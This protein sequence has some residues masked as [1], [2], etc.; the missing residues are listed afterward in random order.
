M[1]VVSELYLSLRLFLETKVQTVMMQHSELHFIRVHRF[2]GAETR[3]RDIFSHL[4]GI[5]AK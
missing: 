4:P 1:F 5:L 3:H 2:L